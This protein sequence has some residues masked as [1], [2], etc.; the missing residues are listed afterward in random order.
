MPRGTSLIDQA[1]LEGRL[2]TP[3]EEGPFLWMDASD[4]QTVTIASGSAVSD[5]RNKIGNSLTFSQS[6]SSYRP[7]LVLQH[8]AGKSALLFDGSNDSLVA[9]G[10]ST[11]FTA[12]SSF[13]VARYTGSSNYQRIF[14][15]ANGTSPDYGGTPYIQLL[16]YNANYTPSARLLSYG[17]SGDS[18]MVAWPQSTYAVIESIHNGS[19]VTNAVN[20]SGEA[21]TNASIGTYDRWGIGD[22]LNQAANGPLAGHV[23]EVVMFSRAADLRLRR[24][25][26]GYLAWGWGL[27]SSLAA[28][29]PFRNRPPLIGD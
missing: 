17:S 15:Q 24:L 28:S 16:A 3:A 10:T 4:L 6:N 1:R 11:A 26:Q 21:T 27:Q 20:G 18:A 25:M 19:S 12:Q 9:V 7:T 8:Q 22:T 13:A 14:T 2:W 29:H 23:G 5:V